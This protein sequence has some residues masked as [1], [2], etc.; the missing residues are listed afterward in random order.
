MSFF[1]GALVLILLAMSYCQAQQAGL[2][3][4]T[5]R[6]VL[7][8]W[9]VGLTAVVGFLFIVFVILIAKRLFFKQQREENGENKPKEIESGE[10]DSDIKQTSL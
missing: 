9:L 8:P 10:V 1:S 6:I 2:R 4:S 5:E 3:A 7:Q